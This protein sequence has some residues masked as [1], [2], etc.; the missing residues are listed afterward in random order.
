MSNVSG[1]PRRP[2][3]LV[4]LDGFGVNPSKRSQPLPSE[5]SLAGREVNLEHYEKHRPSADQACRIGDERVLKS[6]DFQVV[7]RPHPVDPENSISCDVD[8]RGKYGDLHE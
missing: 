2:V 3:V 5:Q 6:P 4:I 7:Y 8:H 1:V